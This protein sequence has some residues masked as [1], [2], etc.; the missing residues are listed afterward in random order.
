MIWIFS[1]IISIFIIRSNALLYSNDIKVNSTIQ[2]GLVIIP[3]LGRKDRLLIVIENLKII[4]HNL[5]II[6]SNM[7][8]DC[9]IYI[10]APREF[11]SFWSMTNEINYMS[12]LCLIIEVPN[13][14]VANNLHMVQPALIYHTYHRVLL[15]LDD[16]KLTNSFHL[17]NLLSIMNR[18]NLTVISPL[19]SIDTYYSYYIINMI[20]YYNYYKI[21]D[22]YYNYFII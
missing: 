6:K 11:L 2:R 5:N 7:I 8:W 15:L 21:N 3:G 10:Y 22:I 9:I 19:V 4:Y 13:Q 12:H 18:N 14:K 20:N 17:E 16:C 1:I